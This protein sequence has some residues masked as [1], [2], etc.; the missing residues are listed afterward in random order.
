MNKQDEVVFIAP[1][2]KTSEKIGENSS[3]THWSSNGWKRGFESSNI[4]SEKIASYE[5]VDDLMQILAD[6]TRFPFI[7]N[8]IVTGHSAGVQF[9]DLYAPAN[10]T[11]DALEGI[12]VHYVVANNQY[13]LG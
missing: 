3:L 6:K 9:T 4:T 10:P 11:E 5:V 2:F 7:E 12:N 13:F 8:I 1:Q